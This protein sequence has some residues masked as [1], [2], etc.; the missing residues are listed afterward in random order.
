MLLRMTARL[1]KL[2]QSRGCDQEL[3]ENENWMDIKFNLHFL[4]AFQFHVS[5]LW[6]VSLAIRLSSNRYYRIT[7]Y[8][9]GLEPG[10][11]G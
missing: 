11:K 9:T 1:W 10:F 2:E 3:G 4:L 8:I 7:G 5:V 6:Q